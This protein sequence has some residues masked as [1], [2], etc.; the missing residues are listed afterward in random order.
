MTECRRRACD[1]H[2][3]CHYYHDPEYYPG[4]AETRNFMADSWRYTPAAS[5][6][7]YGARR[8]GSSEFIEADLQAINNDEAG[9]FVDQTS[10]DILCSLILLRYAIEPKQKRD[11][12]LRP[13]LAP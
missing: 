2:A 1:A 5:P 9:R 10:H 13:Q 3:S 12:A 11:G 8:I 7:R 4:T 6:A